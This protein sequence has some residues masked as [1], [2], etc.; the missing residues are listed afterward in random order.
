MPIYRDHIYPH[1]VSVLGNPKPI[2]EIRQ[3]M[4]PMA[5]EV[6][7]AADDRTGLRTC[8]SQVRSA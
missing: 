2:Q 5:R 1:L 4:V 8:A 6:G 3:R 7:L